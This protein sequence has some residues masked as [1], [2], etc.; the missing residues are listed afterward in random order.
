MPQEDK[1]IQEGRFFAVISYIFF[2]SILTLLFK[3]DNKFALYHAKQGLVLF[4]FE[5]TGFVLSIIPILSWLIH[6]V[7]FAL[8]VIVSVWGL[9]KAWTGEYGRIILISEIAEKIII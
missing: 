6:T 1:E 7:G 3:K 9:F 5:V 8:A 2:L 4:V